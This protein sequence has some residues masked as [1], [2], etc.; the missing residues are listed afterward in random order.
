MLPLVY[1]MDMAASPMLF[2]VHL[3]WVFS[4]FHLQT[5]PFQFLKRLRFMYILGRDLIVYSLKLQRQFEM[6][7]PLVLQGSSVFVALFILLTNSDI[8]IANQNWSW[9][10][11]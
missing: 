7:S 10:G 6:E 5:H 11:E 8:C 9:N 2:L 3:Q 4:T 1:D